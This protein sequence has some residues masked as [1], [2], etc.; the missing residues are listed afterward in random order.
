ML[1]T[2]PIL[3][4]HL[5][6]CGEPV[7]VMKPS[8]H[9]VSF[10][11]SSGY[12]PRRQGRGAECGWATLADSL[13]RSGPVEVRTIHCENAL[14]M[15][16]AEEKDVVQAFPAQGADE[17]LDVG[18][19][20]GREDRCP[21]HSDAR[22]T[23]DAVEGGG[24][25]AVVVAEQELRAVA[26]RSEVSQLL[27]DPGGGGCHRGRGMDELP[28]FEVGHHEDI[29]A[30]EPEVANLDEVAGPDA[31]SLLAKE[32]GP[33]LAVRRLD[34]GPAQVPL[35]GSLGNGMPSL[36]SSPRM[37][38]APQRRFSVPMRRMKW[39][40]SGERRCAL[41]GFR[42]ERHFQKS[43]RPSR[44]Q[45]RSVSGLTSTNMSRQRENTAARATKS[46]RSEAPFSRWRSG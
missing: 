34:A 25:L 29:M 20:L 38:S 33:T 28:R 1:A 43:R 36:R 8:E 31:R 19:R 27:D 44:C 24:E 23:G 11:S 18:G 17:A 3:G 40:T 2:A 9:P 6:S 35:D 39:M 32:G 5:A 42:R 30:A 14:Q 41:D 16:L 46:A 37:R 10:D 7:I 13:V 22:A 21:N 15:D 45:R 12:E 4:S 26:E